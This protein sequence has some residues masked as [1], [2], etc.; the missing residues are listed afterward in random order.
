VGGRAIKVARSYATALA[1]VQRVNVVA[2]ELGCC[3][4]SVLIAQQQRLKIHVT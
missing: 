2:G 1:V 4:S 3:L